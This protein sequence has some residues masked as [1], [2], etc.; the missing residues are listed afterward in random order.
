MMISGLHPNSTEILN[1]I[2]RRNN[3]HEIKAGLANNMSGAAGLSSV[4]MQSSLVFNGADGSQLDLK[5]S[6]SALD[7]FTEL[8]LAHGDSKQVLS[9]GDTSVHGG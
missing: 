7:V 8:S 4:E 6:Q 9:N 3:N 1:Q 2:N 5:A